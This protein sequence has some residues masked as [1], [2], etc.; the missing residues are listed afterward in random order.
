MAS[1]CPH[2]RCCLK[3]AGYFSQCGLTLDSAPPRRWPPGRAAAGRATLPRQRRR[4]RRRSSG[5][6][7]GGGTKG[8]L[9]HGAARFYDLHTAV[10]AGLSVQ[11]RCGVRRKTGGDPEVANLYSAEP[12]C[13]HLRRSM[14][15]VCAQH[16]V[17]RAKTMV[18]TAGPQATAARC[19][20]W[21]APP[22]LCLL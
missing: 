11:I 21:A 4:R 17:S 15:R 19:A 20:C 18:R 1:C 13:R 14:T 7:G 16:I 12:S 2:L 3:L 5:S 8:S 9:V 10:S 6:T 22:V